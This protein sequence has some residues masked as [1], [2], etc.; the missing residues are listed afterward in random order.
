MTQFSEYLKA[1]P[2]PKKTNWKPRK[3]KP[4]QV[5]KLRNPQQFELSLVNGIKELVMGEVVFEC[6]GYKFFIHRMGN[7]WHVSDAVFGKVLAWHEKYNRAVEMAKERIDKN[8]KWYI[9]M[10]NKRLVS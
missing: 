1:N 5:R 8:I 9:D 10:V 7:E 4:V 3:V 6:E 2:R